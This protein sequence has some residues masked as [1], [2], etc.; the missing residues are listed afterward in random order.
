MALPDYVFIDLLEYW[1]LT[2]KKEARG[3]R[4][5]ET[6]QELNELRITGV[7]DDETRDRLT[8]LRIN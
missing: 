7:L 2:L 8:Y 3:K 4:L 6:F 1:A 5:I